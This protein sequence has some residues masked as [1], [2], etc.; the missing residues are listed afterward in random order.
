MTT[1][2][3]PN[4]CD[5]CGAANAE[6]PVGSSSYC[7]ACW[8]CYSDSA[9]WD[10]LAEAEAPAEAMTPAQQMQRVVDLHHKQRKT[11]AHNHFVCP[12]AIAPDYRPSDRPDDPLLDGLG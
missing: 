6:W 5:C 1:H 10:M 8:E 9:Y 12:T 7:Q 2:P 3:L 4:S 11:N